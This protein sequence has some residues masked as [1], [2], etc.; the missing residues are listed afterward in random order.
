MGAWCVTKLRKNAEGKEFL[1]HNL[2]PFLEALRCETYKDKPAFVVAIAGESRRGKSIFENMMLRYLQWLLKNPHLPA[3]SAD[4]HQ[5]MHE[6]VDGAPEFRNEEAVCTIGINVFDRPFVL[7]GADEQE[8][9]VFFV[10]SQRTDGDETTETGSALL[11]AFTLLISNLFIYNVNHEVRAKPHLKNLVSFAGISTEALVGNSK[12]TNEKPFD[13]LM[14]LSRN[15]DLNKAHGIKD[16]SD[17]LDD[18]LGIR[19]ENNAKVHDQIEGLFRSFACCRFASPGKK[20]T[21]DN[22]DGNPEDMEIDFRD[23]LDQAIKFLLADL[24]PKC[25][26]GKPVTCGQLAFHLEQWAKAFDGLDL[27]TPISLYQATINAKFQIASE[28]ALAAYKTTME[29]KADGAKERLDDSTERIKAIQCVRDVRVRAAAGEHEKHERLLAVA[30]DREFERL[31][32]I[33]RLRYEERKKKDEERVDQHYNKVHTEAIDDYRSWVRLYCNYDEVAFKEAHD[34]AS[35]GARSTFKREAHLPE[36]TDE[37]RSKKTADFE[38][39]LDREYKNLLSINEAKNKERKEAEKKREQ[40]Q[41]ERREEERRRQE[42]NARAWQQVGEFAVG[43]V[44][45]GAAV[46]EMF[47]KR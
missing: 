24:Q 2:A 9:V 1:D 16:W 11:F 25:I 4:S 20:V 10:D 12:K 17:R 3:A 36:A 45:F 19:N 18:V 35:N 6:R 37:K 7:K 33:N 40:E 39:E 46:A 27:P 21:D 5:W 26:D 42:A 8:L 22:F 47:F 41:R 23:G 29:E 14:F 15:N 30:L 44:R 43:A 38:A 28:R 34:R 13:K 32:A 31:D